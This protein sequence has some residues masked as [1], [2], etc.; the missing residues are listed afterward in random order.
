MHRYTIT[1]H[2]F[3]NM[4]TL[5]VSSNKT[6]PQS[7]FYH[8]WLSPLPHLGTQPGLHFRFHE[9]DSDTGKNRCSSNPTLNNITKL[10]N[11][12]VRAVNYSSITAKSQL[13]WKGS[14]AAKQCKKKKGKT[15]T[16]NNYPWFLSLLQLITYLIFNISKCSFL[17]L[18]VNE[19]H[20]HSFSPTTCHCLLIMW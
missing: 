16:I 8:T 13:V 14:S 20:N 4:G 18:I 7:Y 5:K 12:T 3:H 10:F 19:E 6:K 1:N 17:Q 15:N 9:C 11:S 2:N